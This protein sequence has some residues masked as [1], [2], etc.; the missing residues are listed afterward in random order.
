MNS[1]ITTERTNYYQSIHK[2]LRRLL[3][4]F[5]IDLGAADLTCENQLQVLIDQYQTLKKYL[6]GHAE[7]ENV[8]FHP[9]ISQY[10]PETTQHLDQ[11]HEFLYKQVADIEVFLAKIFSAKDIDQRLNLG[12]A[13]YLTVNQ[14][15]A[16]YLQHL[17]QEEGEV[18]PSL[19]Q[20]CDDE[21]LMEPLQKF[22]NN[23]TQEDFLATKKDFLPAI[24][25]QERMKL[26]G[27]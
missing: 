22:I 5:S 25:P 8:Y 14:F 27:E 9:F 4:Q 17:Q 19:W 20:K 21:T 15:I 2:T 1:A 6:D 16:G 26:Y 10:I 24:S 11:A 7:H 3:F 12:Y 23:M 18:M 13:L